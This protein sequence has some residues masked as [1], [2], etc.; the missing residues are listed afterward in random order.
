MPFASPLPRMHLKPSSCAPAPSV[1]RAGGRASTTCHVAMAVLVLEEDPAKVRHLIGLFASQ[2]ITDV[3]V[4]A[5]PAAALR[6]VGERDYAILVFDPGAQDRDIGELFLR[7]ALAVLG[8]GQ[9]ALLLTGPVTRALAAM[10]PGL[11]PVGADADERDFGRALRAAIAGSDAVCRSRGY[12][13]RR[14]CP[15]EQ[16]G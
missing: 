4:V 15:I 16:R 10:H 14:P 6:A 1:P 11:V 13:S 7:V 9:P 12:C 3:D 8:A 2:G 5:T